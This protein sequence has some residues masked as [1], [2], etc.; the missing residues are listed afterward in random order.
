[1][2]ALFTLGTSLA[3]PFGIFLGRKVALRKGRP[4]TAFA[5][6]LWAAAASTLAVLL[7]F[8]ILIS[9]IPPGE[10]QELQRAIAEVQRVEAS[11]NPSWLPQPDPVTAKVVQSSSFQ[12]VFGVVGAVIG[13]AI[14]GAIAGTPGWLGTLMLSHAARGRRAA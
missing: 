10:W 11:R 13:F 4:F 14:L 7:V 12:I 8:A 2:S 1:M 9:L 6:W 3:A 5:A